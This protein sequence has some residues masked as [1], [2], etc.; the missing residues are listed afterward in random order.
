M[1]DV[2]FRMEVLFGGLGLEDFGIGQFRSQSVAQFLEADQ[3][4]VGEQ[5]F[6]RGKVK[7]SPQPAHGFL[8][9]GDAFDVRK[10]ATKNRTHSFNLRVRFFLGKA[11]VRG[12]HDSQRGDCEKIALVRRRSELQISSR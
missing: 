6:L 11:N 3:I 10:S 1:A 8:Q 12:V 2:A 7:L 4:E 9:R 5:I